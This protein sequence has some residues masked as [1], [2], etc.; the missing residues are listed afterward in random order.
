M[1]KL[2]DQTTWMIRLLPKTL[3]YCSDTPN[4]SCINF[5]VYNSARHPFP[6]SVSLCVL[7]LILGMHKSS[8][9]SWQSWLSLA[10]Q[11][12]NQRELPWSYT[13]D[14]APLLLQ[15]VFSFAHGC[16]YLKWYSSL[17]P[18]M[19]CFSIQNASFW[20]QESLS[21]SCLFNLLTS[22]GFEDFLLLQKIWGSFWIC[23]EEL[24]LIYM[25]RNILKCFCL[26]FISS[27]YA[28]YMVFESFG[29]NCHYVFSFITRPWF[30]V[31]FFWKCFTPL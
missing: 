30:F 11:N 7:C 27:R 3:T 4:Y 28:R 16:P 23:F 14:S 29:V 1:V 6:I 9:K 24:G 31:G 2:M 10:I 18:L 8:S 22:I 26:S 19:V 21:Y 5:F 20:E 25:G 15:P 12:S 17:D 13:W